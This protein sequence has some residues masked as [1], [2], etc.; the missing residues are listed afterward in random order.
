LSALSRWKDAGV[1]TM[2]DRRLWEGAFTANGNKAVR[3]EVAV[4]PKVYAMAIGEGIE[5]NGM[6]ED[7]L[8]GAGAAVVSEGAAAGVFQKR[9]IKRVF[10]FIEY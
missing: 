4:E 8:G 6:V 7:D 2:R 10:V 1:F 9:I 3:P 5:N